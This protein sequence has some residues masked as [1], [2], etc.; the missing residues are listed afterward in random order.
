M[1][2]EKNRTRAV[3]DVIIILVLTILTGTILIIAC[4]ANPADAYALFFRGI[5]GTKAGFTEIFV[6]ACQVSVVLLLTAQASLILVRKDSF[7]WVP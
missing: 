6:K 3:T 1:Q 4:G 7:M 2:N 5:F